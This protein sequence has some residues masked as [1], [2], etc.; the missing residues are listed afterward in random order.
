MPVYDADGNL[1]GVL[2]IDLTLGELSDFLKVLEIS[3]NGQAFIIERTG[4]MVAT[5][6][7]EPP[8]RTEGEEEIRVLVTESESAL[9][10]TIGAQL[11]E[12]FGGLRTS[13]SGSEITFIEDGETYYVQIA[14]LKDERDSTG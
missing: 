2:G 4:E 5:S 1:Q 13:S 3:P 9:I 10:R 8:F 6:T 14:P 7:D 12:R 11:I